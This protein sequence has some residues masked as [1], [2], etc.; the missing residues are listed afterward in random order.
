M[1]KNGH[2]VFV[3]GAIKAGDI[4]E[5]VALTISEALSIQRRFA[6]VVEPYCPVITGV[7]DPGNVF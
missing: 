7:L 2:V 6:G 1:E 4:Q 3:V 5:R